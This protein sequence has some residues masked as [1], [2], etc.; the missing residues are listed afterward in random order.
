MLYADF[1][2]VGGGIAGSSVGAE[3]APFGATIVVEREAQP[4]YHSTGRSAA[5]YSS[6]YGPPLVRAL[7]RASRAFLEQ[8]PS[9]FADTPILGPRGVLF[10]GPADA[11]HALEMMRADPEFDACARVLAAEAAVSLVPILRTE[12]AAVAV[13]EPEATDID[14]HAL[15]AGYLRLFRARGGRIM[16]N[17]NIQAIEHVGQTWRIHTDVEPIAAR[18]LIN[19]AGA[20]ADEVA[21]LAGV[22][23]LG[24]APLRRTAVLIDAPAQ[25]I[26]SWPVVAS[27]HGDLYFKPDAGKLLLSPMDETP[28][29][30]GD[31]QPDE[32]DVAIAIDRFEGMTNIS[33]RR[34]T[35]RW[36]GLRTF[37]SDRMP[38]AGFEPTS[39]FF[40]LA[41][42][43]GYGI[44]TAP[45]MARA[46]AALVRVG[47]LPA[48]LREQGISATSLDPIRLRAAAPSPVSLR[49]EFN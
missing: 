8:P 4:G 28:T 23:P 29:A 48:D 3:L 20:W 32:L 1:V 16:C 15:H 30:A 5:I 33:V 37:T 24:M 18:V 44:Q 38:V 19:A 14:V 26:G 34:V 42:Q 46:A 45:A 17:A 47:E 25:S 21:A 10:V 35:H 43:G 49:H 31:V 6:L 27:L 36:A 7:T 40:W 12:N 9:G 2:I 39:S 13:H 41:G 11:R 22:A